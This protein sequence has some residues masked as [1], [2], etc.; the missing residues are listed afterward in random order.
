MSLE[1]WQWHV[2]YLIH[3]LSSKAIVYSE[4]KKKKYKLGVEEK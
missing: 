1:D 2:K 4:K 3:Q